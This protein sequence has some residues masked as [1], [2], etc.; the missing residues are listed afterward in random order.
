MRQVCRIIV[1]DNVRLHRECLTS[2]LRL[3]GF[4]VECAWNASSLLRLVG[5]GSVDVIALDSSVPD[6]ETLLDISLD[7]GRSTKVVVYGL[8]ADQPS[9]VVACAE[10]GVAG[11]HLET[12]SFE[13][14]LAVLSGVQGTG[15]RCSQDVSALLMSE[16]YAHARRPVSELAGSVQRLSAREMQVAELLCEG[17]S[18]QQIAKRL[19]VSL[20]TVKNHVH[21]VLGKLGVPTRTEAAELLHTDSPRFIRLL[22]QD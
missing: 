3:E 14:L 7:M 4:T 17:L 15:R 8:P 5:T 2:L 21:G 20:S 19:S 18:N 9:V 6:R 22:P 16:V 10:A 13:Q 1:V 11:L 12:E